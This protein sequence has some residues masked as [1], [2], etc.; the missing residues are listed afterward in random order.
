MEGSGILRQSTVT[1]GAILLVITTNN[2]MQIIVGLLKT[3]FKLFDAQDKGVITIE[4]VSRTLGVPPPKFYKLVTCNRFD[5]ECLGLDI[6]ALVG[7]KF[8]S[9][10]SFQKEPTG[11][12]MGMRQL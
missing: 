10:A 8:E 9:S 1:E 5:D 3:W 12:S 11:K 7:R 2:F 4:D 6:K